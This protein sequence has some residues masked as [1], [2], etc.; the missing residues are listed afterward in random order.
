MLFLFLFFIGISDSGAQ[1]PN[2]S[3]TVNAS[4]YQEVYM[5]DPRVICTTPCSF[6]QDTSLVFIEANRKHNTW[7]KG[8]DIT[9]VYT[10]ETIGI[11]YSDCDWRRNSL[12]CAHDNGVWVLRTIITQDDDKASVNVMMFDESGVMIGQ[13]TISRNKKVT[14]VKR[15]RTTQQQVPGQPM[16]ATNCP[17]GTNTCTTIPINPQGQVTNQTE[18]LEPTIVEVPPALLDRDVGQAMIHMYDSIRVK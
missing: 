10:D 5:E 4:R 2:M 1:E 18:D 14:V 11:A 3:I 12:K 8:G 6:D 17:E 15:Q 7:Y 16:T 9:A 13:G